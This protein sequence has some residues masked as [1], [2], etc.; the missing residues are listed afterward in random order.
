MD[1][2]LS[3]LIIACAFPP[4]STVA[5]HRVVGLCRHL[6][7]SGWRVTVIASAPPADAVIDG[8][9]L[10]AVPATVR[11]VRTPPFDLPRLATRI[12]KGRKE[13]CGTLSPLDRPAASRTSDALTAP[14]RPVRRLL[15]SAVDWLSWWL[16]IP[17]GR[18]GWL[19]PAVCAGLRESRR[20]RPRVVFSTAPVWTAH[21]IGA[22]LSK[23]FRVPLVAD[24]RDPWCGSAFKTIP[25]AAHHTVDRLLERLVVRRAARITCAWDGIRKHLANRYPHRAADIITILNGFD[26]DEINRIPPSRLEQSERLF[27]HIGGFYGPRSPIPLFQALAQLHRFTNGN[28]RKTVF[29]LVGAGSYNG[30]TLAD[31]A[32]EHGVTESVRAL[33]TVSHHEALALLKG[34]D[35]AM[36]FGQSGSDSLASIPAKAYEYIGTRKP[37]LAVGAGEEVCDVMQRGGCRIWRAPADDPERIAGAIQAIVA[38]LDAET[39]ESDTSTQRNSLTRTQM[40]VRLEGVL[41]QVARFPHCEPTVGR[42]ARK[43]SGRVSDGR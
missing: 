25:Y 35:V 4:E 7:E 28:T 13:K 9:L 40:A 24:F 21:L 29:A 37:V 39:H 43:R 32:A 42:R 34:T 10:T 6:A 41:R 11:V 20:C 14:N 18:T 2:Q 31:L 5:V 33:P 1:S 26:E 8:E 36:L 16:H 30:K 19:L 3:A 22:I 17:D 38:F 23:T 12:I 27:L 15:R